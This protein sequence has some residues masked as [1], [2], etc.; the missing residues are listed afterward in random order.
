MPRNMVLAATVIAVLLGCATP[1]GAGTPPDRVTL[2]RA[3]DQW[4]TGWSSGDPG[5]L[6]PLFSDDVVYEDVTFGSVS[7]GQGA[8][9]DFATGVF[10]AFAD[11]A[12]DPKSRFVSADV[13]RGSIEWVFRGRQ[14]KDFPGLPA[15]NRPFEVRGATVV[16]FRDGKIVRNSD[17]WDLMT[18]RTQV[19]LVK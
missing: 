1:R 13:R 9:R 15:T 10:G 11:L 2:E 6:L 19:G 12:F 5:K 17:Y 14:V 4:V 3:L 18:Y 7:R 16:E 8:L